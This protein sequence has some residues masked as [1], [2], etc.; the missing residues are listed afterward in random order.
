M[1]LRLVNG[2]AFI[3]ATLTYRG[4]SLVLDGVL[5]DTGSAGT[6][7]CADRLFTLGLS[8]APDDPIRRLRGVG[9]EEFVFAKSVDCLAVGKLHV[10]DFVIEVG[11]MAYGFT[12]DG[13]LG[14]DFLL[15][16]RAKLNFNQMTLR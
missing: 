15:Q 11:A 4:Q 10:R 6:V 7:F 12:L 3:S 16:T 1:K 8:M 9:G 13:I 5:I 14:L 2:L